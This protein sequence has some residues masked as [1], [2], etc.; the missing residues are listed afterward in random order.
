MENH[1]LRKGRPDD[2]DSFYELLIMSSPH[3]E[4]LF[5]D[6][7]PGLLKHAFA[8]SRNTFSHE[9]TLFIESG[10]APAAMLLSYDWKA[11][12]RESLSTGWLFAS[13]MRFAL[14]P[15]IPDILRVFRISGN[16]YD[17]EY[18][19]SN[20]AVFEKYR[21]RGFARVLMA[22]AE[23]NALDSGATKIALETEEDNAAAIA[24]YEKL[25]FEKTTCGSVVLHGRRVSAQRMVKKLH[26]EHG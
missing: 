26:G 17:G 12:D 14:V 2:A 16:V 9:Q 4:T 10:G 1:I 6:M 19:V 5:G 3:F 21:G 22:E 24:L 8:K 7:C 18:F 25:G 13:R 23:K 11:R 15:L 20:I